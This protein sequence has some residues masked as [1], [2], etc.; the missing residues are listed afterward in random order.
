MKHIDVPNPVVTDL[1]IASSDTL[2]TLTGPR[3]WYRVEKDLHLHSLVRKCWLFVQLTS[4]EALSTNEKVI[5]DVCI[6]GK[7]QEE[8]INQE[9]EQRRGGIWLRRK[10]FNNDIV[11]CVT[12]ATV[13]FGE[14]A[15]DPRPQW[16]LLQTPLSTVADLHTPAPRLSIRHGR[17]VLRKLPRS[18]T[19]NTRQKFRILQISDTHM[20]TGTGICK[21][22]IDASGNRVPNF[23][24]DPRTIAFIE[25]I[26]DIEK[27]DLV[28]LAGDQLHHGIADTETALYKV[29]APIIKKSIPFAAVFG[30]HDDE[31][32]HV[33]SRESQLHGPHDFL[34]HL[35]MR[36]R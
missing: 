18:L 26:L 1:T 24:A 28:I 25:S 23:P 19:M 8:F 4:E 31:G 33:L 15:V 30:N 11:R 35:L 7:H 2:P 14:D 34:E 20:V 17:E 32:E 6:H 22:A 3:T 27:P 13:L 5:Y 29:L 16:S 9:W 21:D 12:D 36:H 10:A